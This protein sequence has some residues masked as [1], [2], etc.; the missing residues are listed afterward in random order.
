MDRQDLEKD[1]SRPPPQ[2]RAQVGQAT[3]QK[4]VQSSSLLA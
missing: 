4:S 3:L 2:R 1:P